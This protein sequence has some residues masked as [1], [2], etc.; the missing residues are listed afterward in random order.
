MDMLTC[1]E[2]GGHVWVMIFAPSGA[3][4]RCQALRTWGT[5]L[6]RPPLERAIK[7]S[8]SLLPAALKR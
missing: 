3:L 8:R 1:V 7:Y 5:D 4:R 2:S 6:A